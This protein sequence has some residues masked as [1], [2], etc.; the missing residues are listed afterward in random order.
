[1]RPRSTKN[2]RTRTALTRAAG[3]VAESVER[4]VLMA[5]DFSLSNGVLTVNGT[6]AADS[7]DVAP[8]SNLKANVTVTLNGVSSVIYVSAAKPVHRVVIN[9]GAGGDTIFVYA[10]N[11]YPYLVDGSGDPTT[12]FINSVSVSAGPGA[13]DVQFNGDHQV[14]VTLDG[15]DGNDA[16]RGI[17]FYGNQSRLA[18]VIMSG[19]AGD[20]VIGFTFAQVS[21][22]FMS[23]GPGND[24]FVH[25]FSGNFTTTA[26]NRAATVSGGDGVDTI[27]LYSDDYLPAT[28]DMNGP[29]IQTPNFAAGPGTTIGADVENV[30]G[31]PGFGPTTIVGNGLNNTFALTGNAATVFGSGGDDTFVGAANGSSLSGGPGSDTAD[32]SAQ[33]ADL[34]IDLGNYQ[35]SGPHD[36]FFDGSVEKAVG[37]SGNDHIYGSTGP[38]SLQGN[39]G[40][41]SLYG[42]GGVDALFGGAGNDTMSASGGL[43]SYVD[44]GTG[45]A[46][47]AYVDLRLDTAYNVES[48]FRYNANGYFAPNYVKLTGTTF[49]TAGSY[50]NNGNTIAKA[51]DGNLATYFDATAASGAFVGIDLGSALEV[52]QIRFAPR[53]GSAARMVGGSFQASNDKTFANGTAVVYT[54]S[55]APTNGVLTVVPVATGT[56]AYRYWRYVAPANS[57]GN[58]AE[59]QLFGIPKAAKLTGTTF[60]TAGSYNN[61]GNTVAKAT[62]GNLS[63]YFDAPT[64][65]G[66]F[67]GIDIGLVKRTVTQIKFAPRSGYASRM[68]GGYF[69]ASTSASFGAFDSTI[70]YSVTAAPASGGLTTV[71][72]DVSAG[73]RYWRYVAPANSYGNVA[74]FQLFGF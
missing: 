28:I 48:I 73:Y 43:A 13:D 64:A 21:N 71:N 58:V 39:G 56:T 12:G 49:G 50:N 3:A 23:G 25:L 14:P 70:A 42:E 24:R 40:N 61:N 7:I 22:A 4:R 26:L 46:D 30:S 68:V 63:T 60:G 15:G 72:V 9:A 67:V 65:A 54:V 74:E 44:G 33:T 62:D 51:T 27:E 57:Y 41:D 19:G 2:N 66:G 29:V 37:G 35:P 31:V 45:T 10:Q 8:T 52:G 38:N 34:V 55:T 17:S 6:A 36:T 20:D 11:E 32:Y 18:N 5:A 53:S 69:Q 16:L 59:V 1:M 47:V